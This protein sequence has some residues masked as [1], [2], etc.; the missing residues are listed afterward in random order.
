MNTQE[1]RTFL[2]QCIRE[3]AGKHHLQCGAAAIKNE[4]D[5]ILAE[6][7][8]GIQIYSAEDLLTGISSTNEESISESQYRKGYSQGYETATD[9]VQHAIGN[10]PLWKRMARF[11]DTLLSQWRKGPINRFI[12][13]PTLSQVKME[14]EEDSR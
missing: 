5:A 13:P 12:A 11:C 1:R 4:I 7:A 8:P 6:I 9:N 3:A 14:P 10:I 2:E